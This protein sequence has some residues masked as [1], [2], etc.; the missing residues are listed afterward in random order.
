MPWAVAKWGAWPPSWRPIWA[1][2]RRVAIAQR[3]NLS[4]IARKPGLKAVD[5]FEA[6]REKRVRALWVIATNPAISL[7]DSAR[8]REALAN[9]ELLIVWR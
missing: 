2:P 8:V 7:P 5:L 9:C 4:T 3:L 1:L 6:V